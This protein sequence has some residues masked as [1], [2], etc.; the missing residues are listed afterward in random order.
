M[1]VIDASVWVA[2][3]RH[4]RMWRRVAA[5][6]MGVLMS[7]CWW[8]S[9]SAATVIKVN[10][11]KETA[12]FS[13]SPP[14]YSSQI[15][16][17]SGTPGECSLRE[18]IEAADTHAA[19]FGCPAGD[20]NDT[21]E[22]IPG[23]YHILDN[24]FIK[25]KMTF[26]GPNKGLAGNDPKRGPEAVLS[27][28]FNPFWAAQPALFWLD[29]ANDTGDAKGAGTAFDGVELQGGFEPDCAQA[30]PCEII[31]I[32]QPSKIV[33]LGYTLTDSIVRH[34]SF[35]VY[36]GGHDTITRDLFE[37][38]DQVPA[39][40][41]HGYDIYSDL[42]YTAQNPMIEHNVFKNPL[43]SGVLIQGDANRGTVVGGVIADNA[44]LKE[45]NSELGVFVINTTGVVIK[46][47]LFLH[48]NPMPLPDR[49]DSAIRLDKDT[50]IQITGNTIT[51]WGAA[52]S[53]GDVGTPGPPGSTDITVAFN[54]IYNNRWGVKV[55]PSVFDTM[56]YTP[57]AVDANDNW[58]GA[59]GG[60]G[61]VGARPGAINPVNGVQFLE[62]DSTTPVPNQGGITADRSLQLT[63][64]VPATVQVN[65]PAPVVGQV[66]GMP[67]VDVTSSTPPWFIADSEPL[68]A[69]SAPGLANV[70]G[71]DQV[72]D[73]GPN[74][75]QLTGTLLATNT[76]GGDVLVDLDSEQVACPLTVTP[77][78]NPD[79]GKDPDSPTVTAGGLAGYRIT[80]T[81]RGSVTARNWWVCDSI[82]RRMTFVR[83]TR[84][85][86]RLGRLRCLVIPTL[87]PH[88]R[89]S[90]HLT[91]RVASNAPSAT[92]TNIG[93]VIPG[94]PGG[95]TPPVEVPIGKVE[96]KDKVRRPVPTPPAPPPVTG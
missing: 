20:G 50:N 5:V 64:T 63:C 89:V 74:N 71:F 58:W 16:G 21:I 14:V 32:V 19:V 48:P 61:L 24:F 6:V 43:V 51:G 94:P 13:P 8:A 56:Q 31:A 2:S 57:L 36:L 53:V 79:I 83:A 85:L 11:L 52:I 96:A 46:D 4:G 67:T 76:G 18:A 90:F 3:S 27:L 88:E 30:R 44:V 69:A 73:Q 25:E 65:V 93:E 22:L 12:I 95:G 28:D 66:L 38:N 78:P 81:N 92:V 9:S 60:P 15:V 37:D 39:S 26:L 82:P 33:Q 41:A 1:R 72:P 84:K 35:G 77:G 17:D 62:S 47:N 42:V 68:M 70:F 55:T 75:A 86:R 7:T 40:S 49:G 87:K 91:L 45:A 29:Q 34:F 59:N 54:R 80:V 23:V 10:T